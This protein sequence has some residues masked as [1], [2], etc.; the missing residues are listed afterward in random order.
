M[1]NSS[2][3]LLIQ[4]LDQFIRKYYLNKVLRGALLWTA[5]ILLVFVLFSFFEHQFYFGK[6]VRKG[7][8][9]V[10]LLTFALGLGYWIVMPLLKYFRLGNR[11]S[12]EQAAKI[13]G[14]HFPDVNDRLLN[15]LQLKTQAA[16]QEDAS[17]IEASINQKSVGI[18]LVPF[19][20]AI[21]LRENRKYLKYALPPFLLLIGLLFIDAT[22][23]TDS[24]YRIINNSEDFEREAPFRYTVLNDDL[25]AVEYEDFTLRVSTK[26]EIIP[27][28]IFLDYSGYQYRLQKRTGNEF[29]HT[30]NN[31]QE[32]IEFNLFSGNVVSSELTLDVLEKPRVLDYLLKLTYPRY[33]AK[34]KETISN[35]GDVVIPEGTQIDWTINTKNTDNVQLRFNKSTPVEAKRNSKSQFNHRAKFRNNTP[36]LLSFSSDIVPEGD[37]LSFYINVIKDKY[38]SI[39]LERFQDSVENSLFFFAG[40]VG[41]DYGLKKLNFKYD[42][43][44]KFGSIR[45]TQE[46]SVQEE[47]SNNDSFEYIFDLNEIELQPGEEVRYF[48][49]VFDNDQINGSK[50]TKSTVMKYRKATTEEFKEEEQAN[51]EE[52]NKDL[53]ESIK[54]IEEMQRKM[55][56]LRED[57]LQKKE[58]DWQDKKK[59]EELLEKQMDIQKKLEEAKQRNEQNLKN[60]EEY[61]KLPEEVR[62]KQERLQELFEEMTSDES[63]ELMEKIQELMDEMNKEQSL[64]LLNEMQL[65]QENME[66]HAERLNELYKQLEVE[67]EMNEAI[68]ELNKLAEELDELS[69]ETQDENSNQEKLEEKHEEINKEF[70]DLKKKMEEL[71]EKNDE[72]EYPKPMEDDAPEQMEEI[73]DELNESK[74]ELKQNQK[75]SSSQKQKSA[76]GKMKKMA[77]AMQGD[78]A[79]A[80]MDQMQEDLETLRQLL[81]NIITLSF[82]QE[83]IVND[84]NRSRINTPKYTSLT[85]DQLKIKD[86]FQIVED[87]LQELSKRQEKIE[88]FITEKVNE[89]NSNLDNSMVK[90][91][92]REKAEAHQHQ[93]FSMKN[94]NDLA[95]MLSESMEQMQR[96]MSGMMQGSQMCN[97]PGQGKSGKK[98]SDKISEGQKGLNKKLKEIQDKM[99][100]GKN[101]TAKE[102]AE[103]AAQQ[104]ALRKALQELMK[105]R[106]EEGKGASGELQDII[107]NMDKQEV[108]L[109]NKRLDNEMMK[110][111]QDILSRLLDAENAERQ[112]EF[113]NKRKSNEG[114]DKERKLPPSLEEYL[115]KRNAE[116][117][118]FKNTSPELNSYYQFL[119]DE[120]FRALKAS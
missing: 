13:L 54:D 2:Y 9:G 24:T 16:S 109:V 14:E 112:R 30:F 93:R 94:L 19:R 3:D 48:F 50:S 17:L 32:D 11:I 38:P 15:I 67:K 69:E 23:I 26:G 31:L 51:E 107:N 78:M 37:S 28:E 10:F 97:K 53:E 76:A 73:N 29:T 114:N 70:E 64:Q 82:D 40:N 111:Q 41:D 96:Q 71:K 100:N 1:V 85:Q 63:K 60:Q 91:E 77:E 116:T 45:S 87:S 68:D 118:F 42:I 84:L 103:A 35:I 117:D 34:Q 44:T 49:E 105:Q 22:I 110:R 88:S 46:K 108:D 55:Q 6:A 62:E 65:E 89:V 115:K 99:K 33:T 57:L 81:E 4:K 58:M 95:L 79:G 90:L 101:G 25:T 75:Q 43:L 72:L 104:A 113:E 52:I 5:L 7:L 12:H 59:M 21:D 61:L 98:P 119:V 18:R 74:E 80:E 36:Y 27:E 56:K 102:F 86:D 66:K 20:K 47:L 39:S 83:N 92:A 8:F 120:Y 106:Q